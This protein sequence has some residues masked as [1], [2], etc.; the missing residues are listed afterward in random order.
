MNVLLIE[1]DKYDDIILKAIKYHN[2]YVIG[3]DVNKEEELF[4]KIIRDADKLDIFN[5]AINDMWKD[6][7]ENI[8]S[9]MISPK[10]LEQVLSCKVVDKKN[11][12]NNIDRVIVILAFIY[13][14][15]FKS[16]YEIIQQN[17]YIDKIINR[18]EFKEEN[19]KQMEDIRKVANEYINKKLKGE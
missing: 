17:K 18:F 15:N 5:I 6:Q 13:D 12:K 3:K 1:T 9:Q 10:V 4:C 19:K 11:L 16:S 2:K 8:E 14:F 7:K